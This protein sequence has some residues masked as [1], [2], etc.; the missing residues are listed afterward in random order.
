MCCPYCLSEPEACDE[1]LATTRKYRHPDRE[2]FI[3][4]N[5]APTQ[6]K[7]DAVTAHM[8]ATCPLRP[9]PVVQ[10]DNPFHAYF[11]RK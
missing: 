9:R 8:A 4:V 2:D 6:E 10:S 7:W 3:V 11:R 5:R 1:Y